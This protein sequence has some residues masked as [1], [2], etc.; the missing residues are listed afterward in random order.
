M[1]NKSSGAIYKAFSDPGCTLSAMCSGPAGTLLV[2]DGENQALLQLQWQEDQK[3]LQLVKSVKL[4]AGDVQHMCYVERYDLVVLSSWNSHQ[5]VAV[6]LSTGA[7]VWQLKGKVAGRGLWSLGVSCD[8]GRVYIAD[9][10][11]KRVLV[12]SADTGDLLQVALEGQG[13]WRIHDVLWISNT[14]QLLVKHL[15]GATIYNITAQ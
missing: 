13:L 2:Y 15:H 11:N 1:I 9:W 6:K 12:V 7:G 14:N 3:K 5:V 10:Y 8:G 4:S